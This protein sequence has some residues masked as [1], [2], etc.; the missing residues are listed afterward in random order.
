MYEVA[1]KKKETSIKVDPTLQAKQ[2]KLNRMNQEFEQL[3]NRQFQARRGRN[4]RIFYK[5]MTKTIF[6]Y[7]SNDEEENVPKKRNYTQFVNNFDNYL[8]S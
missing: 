1:H 8:E 4:D 2:E 3:K 7:E 6:D 5:A